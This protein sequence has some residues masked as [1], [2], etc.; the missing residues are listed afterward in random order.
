MRRHAERR[1]KRHR[2]WLRG[3]WPDR[4]PLRRAVDR[5]EAAIVAGLLAAFVAGAPLAALA[6]GNWSHAVG[7]RVEHAQQSSWHQVPATLLAKAPYPGYTGYEA[8]VPARWTAQNGT[9]LSGEIPAPG[10]AK[11][12]STLLVWVDAAGHLTGPPLRHDQVTGQAALAAL[13]AALGVGMLVLCARLV[14]HCGLERRRLA[15]WDSDWQMTEP[16]WTS[17]H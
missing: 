9:R 7:S 3:L 15:A 4:N 5:V 16:Q 14:A 17:R 2:G 13:L 10:G 1:V 6:V 8:Q 11:A 12:G